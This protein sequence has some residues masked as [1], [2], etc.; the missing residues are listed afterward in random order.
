MSEK[1]ITP[2]KAIR[3][4]CVSCVGGLEAEVHSCGGE[5]VAEF[6]DENEVCRFMPYRFGKGR[7]SVKLIRAFCLCCMG[8][9]EKF[10]RECHEMSCK[11]WGFRMGHNPNISAETRE[12]LKARAIAH[13][14]VK[15][16]HVSR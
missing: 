3:R 13:G 8:D 4:H 6:G 7:P 10:V 14:F 5:R 9:S 16:T 2:V 11:L 1:K 12:Q 15:K